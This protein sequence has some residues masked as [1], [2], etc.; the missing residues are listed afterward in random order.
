MASFLLGEKGGEK[1]VE[2]SG[3]ETSKFHATVTHDAQRAMLQGR[4][5][6]VPPAELPRELYER[7][8]AKLDVYGDNADLM[9]SAIELALNDT[10]FGEKLSVEVGES[11]MFDDGQPGFF[12]VRREVEQP[13]F[14]FGESVAR[15]VL[16]NKTTA[17]GNKVNGK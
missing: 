15:D 6:A 3:L 1:M 14:K 8:R 17:A 10:G 11:Q 16:R 4:V 5:E 9:R 7:A 2:R 13:D 12:L